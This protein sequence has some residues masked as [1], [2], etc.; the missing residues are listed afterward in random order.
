MSDFKSRLEVEKTEL[1]EKLTKLSA[2][3]R[4]EAFTCIDKR[5]QELLK[6]QVV[7]MREYS[8]ILRLRIALLAND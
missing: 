4:S 8:V 6:E 7:V 1:D 2:F 3:L 5:Q